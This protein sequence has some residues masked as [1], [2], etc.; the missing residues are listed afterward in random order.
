MAS[1]RLKAQQ[2]TFESNA[3]LATNSVPWWI[4]KANAERRKA[5]LQGWHSMALKP[6]R[7]FFALLAALTFTCM[8][9]TELPYWLGVQSTVNQKLNKT[10]LSWPTHKAALVSRSHRLPVN[11]TQTLLSYAAV[12]IGE[13]EERRQIEYLLHASRFSY[14]G[15]ERPEISHPR[16]A[17]YW[18]AFRHA[19]QSWVQNKRYE[20]T[21][22][23]QLIDL[24]KQPL[25][26]HYMITNL[27]EQQGAANLSEIHIDNRTEQHGY[28]PNWQS[29]TGQK[30][31]HPVD[32]QSKTGQNQG[33]PFDLQSKTGQK[34][35]YPLD[36][37][38][39][40][41]QKQGHQLDRQSETGQK[42]GYSLDLL[43]LQSKTERKQGYRSCAVVGN[44]GI[45]LQK[46]H[47]ALIDSHDM[48]IRL[49]NARTARFE[50]HVG[51]KTTLAFVNSNVFH[52]CSLRPQCLC[53][54]YGEA[55]PIIMYICQ[56][57]HFMDYAFC[58]ASKKVPLLVTDARFDNLC[59][60]IV[61][62]YSMKNFVV[63][64]GKHPEEWSSAHEGEMF[65]YSSGMQALMLALGICEKVSLFGFGKS[66]GAKHHYHTNQ[67]LELS[68]H[69]YE[70]EYQFYSDLVN[71]S[72]YIPFLNEAGIKI[73]PV[74]IYF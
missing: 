49:N 33:Y 71:G 5:D 29:K 50:S 25:D 48:V 31:G 20:P 14:N 32:L 69:D 74:Q 58:N 64:T 3:T 6:L 61:K 21:V 2:P 59:A 15:N 30:Q 18:P 17:N 52:F 65:H 57:V 63:T 7:L 19:L 24:V 56:P 62:Y 72:Q 34:Q 16:Y 41:G 9:S 45:L 43:D 28:P 42:Q 55:V 36:L 8:L 27:T 46:L 73:P 13:A 54:S 40:P 26:Q 39:K 23:T 67:R 38:S 22:M 60:R 37:Q 11:F 66:T 4:T 10:L 70:A 44:S 53:H 68:L 35:G 51:S 47:G 12:Q 1:S